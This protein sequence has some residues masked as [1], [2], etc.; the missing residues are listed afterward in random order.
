[1]KVP[2][3][4]ALLLCGALLGLLSV[5]MGALG[6]H[7]LGLSSQQAS[8][9]DTAIRYNMLYA[10]LISVIAL[11]DTSKAVVSGWV[12]AVG[13][14]LFCG[15]IYTALLIGIGGLT[16]LTPLG[17]LGIMAGWLSLAWFAVQR[18]I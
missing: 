5:I 10:V 3:I 4:N 1:M 6:D 18:E 14:A 7:A 17:G 9:L 16:Y 2:A 12:F 13:T 8:S 15:G 11:R